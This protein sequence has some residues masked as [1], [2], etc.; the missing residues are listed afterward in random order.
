[1]SIQFPKNGE[2]K[3]LEVIDYALLT[4]WGG[5]LKK[6]NK[7]EY[8]FKEG[9]RA[10]FYHQIVEGKIK[11]VNETDDGKDF[12]QGFFSQG[13]SFGEPPVFECGEYPAS[14]IA[15]Q[16]SVIIRLNIPS[17]KQMLKENFEVHW[18]MT[19]LLAKRVKNKAKALKEISFHPPEHRILSVLES[20]RK[21]RLDGMDINEKIKVEYTRKQIANM[22]G[23]RVETVIRVM[24]HLYDKNILTIER[25]K[26]YY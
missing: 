16:S 17:F 1:M 4:R 12:I 18:K 11:M 5:V 3:R 15:V 22:T 2:E 23:L 26:V 20:Y 19:S 8:I 6:Y 7:D 24:R 21:E 9:Q 25:G 10:L 13:E 14:A